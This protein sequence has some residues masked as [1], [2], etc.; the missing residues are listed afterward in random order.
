MKTYHF[1][2]RF[3]DSQWN[4]HGTFLTSFT[5]QSDIVNRAKIAVSEKLAGWHKQA[6]DMVFFEV[7][8]FDDTGKE[9]NI[10]K[11]VA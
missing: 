8:C 7:Y 3:S 2:A 10:F 9:I 4:Y 11:H 1:S 6:K 5:E